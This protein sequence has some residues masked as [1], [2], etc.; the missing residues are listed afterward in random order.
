[1]R[2]QIHI[3]LREQAIMIRVENLENIGNHYSTRRRSSSNDTVAAVVNLGRVP[4]DHL[5]ALQ[6]VHGHD[7]PGAAGCLDKLPPKMARVESARPVQGD[8]F[9]RGR[10]PLPRHHVPEAEPAPVGGKVDGPGRIG[11]EKVLARFLERVANVAE[12]IAR[13]GKAIPS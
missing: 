2:T 4:D 11:V 10:V 9:Q 12:K 8:F 6:V 1:M 5:V 3:L 13:D 7:A